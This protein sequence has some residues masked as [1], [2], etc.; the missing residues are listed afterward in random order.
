[1]MKRTLLRVCAT[2]A[3][4]TLTACSPE[5]APDAAADPAADLTLPLGPQVAPR[6]EH[7]REDIY[8]YWFDL[9]VGKTANA[10][11]RVHR[12]V[13]ERSPYQPYPT[14]RAILLLHGDFATFVTN[15][16]PS[17]GPPPVPGAGPGALPGR[18][19]HRRLGRRP[20]LDPARHC[21]RHL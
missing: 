13:R 17:L 12:V 21:G 11:V 4:A 6:R 18:A 16:A 2:L 9:P 15:F 19:R 20:P 3:C 1:M 7:V 14:R 10:R 5:A 8:H